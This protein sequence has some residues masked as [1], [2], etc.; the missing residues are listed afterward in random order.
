[1]ENLLFNKTFE[2]EHCLLMYADSF[3]QFPAES[4]YDKKTKADM[5]PVVKDCH[6]Y[7]IGLIP[8]VDF[9]G[10]EKSTHKLTM[11]FDIFGQNIELDWPNPGGSDLH[12][13]ANKFSP[14]DGNERHFYPSKKMIIEKLRDESGMITFDVQYIGQAYG[15]DGSRNAM[16]RLLKHETLQKIAVQGIPHGYD[17]QILMLAIHESNTVMTKINPFA[18]N[19]DVGEVRFE[20]GQDKLFGTS[21]QERVSLY[22]AALIRYFMPKFNHEFKHSFPSTNL[23][24]LRDCYDKDFSAIAAEINFDRLPYYLCS[25]TV[26]A[27]LTHRAFFDLHDDEKRKVFFT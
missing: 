17:L 13:D 21:K 18:E 12:F 3:I 19:T 4:I 25:D 6:I 2:I 22:E 9:I 24:V 10:E 7:L 11:K 27:A 1:M 8:T 5:P 14:S 20:A 16:N 23:K 26:K 15:S